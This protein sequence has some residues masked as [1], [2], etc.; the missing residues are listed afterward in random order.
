M[1]QNCAGRVGDGPWRDYCRAGA[2]WRFHNG[3]L[4]VAPPPGKGRGAPRNVGR[5][6]ASCPGQ[7]QGGLEK[8]NE[9]K[10]VL[11]M[12]LLLKSPGKSR[13]CIQPFHLLEPAIS[14]PEQL[15]D[16]PQVA[17][18][19]RRRPRE[20]ARVRQDGKVRLA[21]HPHAQNRETEAVQVRPVDLMVERFSAIV[22]F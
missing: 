8:S 5:G 20:A 16:G 19:L 15:G 1:L 9:V 22:E 10:E 6:I 21:I 13:L 17:E 3:D 14:R 18:A 11:R 12:R 7:D 4:V 2:E